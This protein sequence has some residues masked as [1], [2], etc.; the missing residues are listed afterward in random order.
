MK[1]I[2]KLKV[3]QS[4]SSE[5]FHD[6][7]MWCV[8]HFQKKNLEVKINNPHTIVS[9]DNEILYIAV[10]EGYENTNLTINCRRI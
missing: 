8:N 5:A 3:V 4:S 2:K 10:V 7:L 1:V 6:G 9:T